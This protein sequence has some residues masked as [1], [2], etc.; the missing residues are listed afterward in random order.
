MRSPRP[1]ATDG[2]LNPT[3]T[4][5]TSGCMH[6]NGGLETARRRQM[7][8]IHDLITGLPTGIRP[9]SAARSRKVIRLVCGSACAEG[10][11]PD[12]ST[13]SARAR[14]VTMTA[15]RFPPNAGNPR[16]VA[17]ESARSATP[18]GDHTFVRDLPV[19]TPVD[20]VERADCSWPRT[21]RRCPRSAEEVANRVRVLI[22]SRGKFPTS[23][24]PSSRL[25]LVGAAGRRDSVGKL[26]ASRIRAT[27]TPWLAPFAVA[28]CA[29]RM[30]KPLHHGY[31]PDLAARMVRSMPSANTTPSRLGFRPVG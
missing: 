23:T 11:P 10:T 27:L 16:R 9:T 12:A 7:V 24:A 4:A 20:T 29:I 15:T 30:T 26:S 18:A 3:T 13:L 28:V 17:H 19:D 31:P 1:L 21:R 25:H 22:P 2:E 6:S 5:W 8:P 14:G